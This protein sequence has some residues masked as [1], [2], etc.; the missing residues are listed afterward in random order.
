M[1]STT[2]RLVSN[3]TENNTF[4][5]LLNECHERVSIQQQQVTHFEI[6]PYQQVRRG[7]HLKNLDEV[8]TL[9]QHLYGLATAHEMAYFWE[10][11][12]L[13]KRH[14]FFVDIKDVLEDN[15]KK[16][17]RPF[18][19]WLHEKL[20]GWNNVFE[21]DVRITSMEPIHAVNCTNSLSCKLIRDAS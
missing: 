20:T 18:M 9:E 13:D 11:L 4:E 12:D 14:V 3:S 15:L 17:M 2:S 6:A 7:Y 21:K 1:T 19:E 8:K 16:L 10:W 5:D